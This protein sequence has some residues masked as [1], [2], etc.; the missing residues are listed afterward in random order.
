V[1]GDQVSCMLEQ[2]IPFEQIVDQQRY[3]REQH[4]G[5]AW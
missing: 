5:M 1:N 3:L 2:G 4:R